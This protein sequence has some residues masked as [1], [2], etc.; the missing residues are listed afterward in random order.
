MGEAR[1]IFEELGDRHAIAYVLTQLGDVY[2]LARDQAA[3]ARCHEESLAVYRAI[4]SH[5]GM[6]DAL[7][8]LGHRTTP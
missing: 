4:G 7:Q 2:H 1:A 3:A 5:G 8:R 6:A